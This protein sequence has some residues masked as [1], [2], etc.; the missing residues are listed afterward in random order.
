MGCSNQSSRELAVEL[1]MV[2]CVACNRG[3]RFGV[4][5]G[6]ALDKDER[7]EERVCLLLAANDQASPDEEA[8]DVDSGREDGDDCAGVDITFFRVPCLS[9]RLI[10][11]WKVLMLASVRSED[12]SARNQCTAWGEA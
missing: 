2:P 1:S 10:S 3:D 5:I 11:R 6:K 4:V 12:G 8:E 7:E 9:F